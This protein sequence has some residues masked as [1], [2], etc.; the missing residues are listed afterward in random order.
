MLDIRGIL[1][2]SRFHDHHAIDFPW[3]SCRKDNVRVEGRPA[4]NLHCGKAEQKNDEKF[5]SSKMLSN[6][7]DLR[8]R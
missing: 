7:I 8:A 6:N 3:S 2:K 4:R 1:I 5:I